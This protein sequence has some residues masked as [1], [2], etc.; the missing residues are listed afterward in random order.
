M[1]SLLD[2]VRADVEADEK[3]AFLLLDRAALL[4]G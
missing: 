1:L 3:A 2:T 4:A